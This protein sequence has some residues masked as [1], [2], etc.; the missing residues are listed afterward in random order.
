LN[1]QQRGNS[2]P[3]EIK[4]PYAFFYFFRKGKNSLAFLVQLSYI[5]SVQP[6][7]DWFSSL[8]TFTFNTLSDKFLEISAGGDIFCQYNL[9]T[10]L[11]AMVRRKK[12]C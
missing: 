7:F 10:A 1:L 9:L 2:A 6:R 5:E 4:S 11:P 8:K 12:R 3:L